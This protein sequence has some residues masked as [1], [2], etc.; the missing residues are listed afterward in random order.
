MITTIVEDINKYLDNLSLVEEDTIYY[1]K[2]KGITIHRCP[3]KDKHPIVIF[4]TDKSIDKVKSSTDDSRWNLALH[5][6]KITMYPSLHN[7]PCN[8]HYFI[9]NSNI[10]EV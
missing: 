1:E 9:E 2:E 6:D 4:V 7:R 3:C 10:R 5:E 8:T